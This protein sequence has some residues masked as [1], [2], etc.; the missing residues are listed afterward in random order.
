MVTLNDSLR[1][2]TFT[3]L[4]MDFLWFA[5]GQMWIPLLVAILSILGREYCQE[6]G[7]LS[8]SI[9]T[10]IP[11]KYRKKRAILFKIN[12]SSIHILFSTDNLPGTISIVLLDSSWLEESSARIKSGV[13]TSQTK[14]YSRTMVG[15][16]FRQDPSSQIPNHLESIFNKNIL[17]NE[18][19]L[20]KEMNQ[21]SFLTL[22]V[23]VQGLG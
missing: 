7:Q 10:M 5:V 16:H 6:I 1:N 13:R 19:Q 23:S 11:A 21:T 18:F 4:Q 3:N 8:R 20:I 14:P 17:G 15:R 9:P 22:H 12:Q 2:K